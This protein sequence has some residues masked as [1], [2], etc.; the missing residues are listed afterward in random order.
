MSSEEKW[1][2]RFKACGAIA[3]IVS[4]IGLIVGGFFGLY[5]YRHQ[6]MASDALKEKELRLMQ[7]SQKKDVYSELVD[8]AASVATSQ[9]K[10][11]A[12]KNAIKYLTLL[13]ST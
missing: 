8:A 5:S 9:T 1:E 6:G 13:L 7:Y 11:D 10:E 12:M 4:A 3:A 2:L